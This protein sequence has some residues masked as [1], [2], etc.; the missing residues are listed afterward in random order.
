VTGGIRGRSTAS[1]ALLAF[2]LLATASPALADA[3]WT[4]SGE[5]LIGE[6]T[7]E[8]DNLRVKTA[9][10]PRGL[11]V[12]KN[13]V[14]ARFPAALVMLREIEVAVA[15]ARRLMSDGWDP[16]ADRQASGLKAK[17]K[18]AE[19]EARVAKVEDVYPDQA[20]ECAEVKRVIA[21]A[22]AFNKAWLGEKGEK[23]PEPE[24]PLKIPSATPGGG[25]PPPA[26]SKPDSTPA[27][28]K[29]PEIFLRPPPGTEAEEAEVLARVLEQRL[30][31]FGFEGL[32]VT[33]ADHAGAAVIRVAHKE[34]LLRAT[35]ERIR[36]FGRWRGR[37]LEGR[38][39]YTMSALE[40]DSFVRPLPAA[41]DK[42]PA[43]DGSS[44][45]RLNATEVVL[46]AE[47]PNVPG[48]ALTTPEVT[49][50]GLRF[51]LPGALVKP[52]RAA[53]VPP[54]AGLDW[55][56]FVFVMDGH[57]FRVEHT[58]LAFEGTHKVQV[59]DEPRM[60]PGAGGGMRAGGT[61]WETRP[62]V[63]VWAATGMTEA[64]WEPI[65]I[66]LKYPLK[67]ELTPEE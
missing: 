5:R 57:A 64:A 47:R 15:E 66:A 9:L 18:L 46:L 16:K 45:L 27:D 6:V 43:P 7:E 10:A 20:A 1:G 14:M 28:A 19:C 23:T 21:E 53:I 54:A 24:A 13:S 30:A 63:K 50:E 32:S 56:A 44:W 22:V 65:R 40:A 17:E 52:L 38:L 55:T 59:K 26:L 2:A 67:V 51:E 12:P 41:V 3:I 62:G 4:K 33:V 49:K 31:A 48:T 34:G 8:G 25:L 36:W 61:H 58:A 37:S 35:C 39:E 29:L 42:A 60:V 11:L